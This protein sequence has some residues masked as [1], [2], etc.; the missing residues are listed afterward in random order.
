[1]D[2]IVVAAV[3]FGALL[4]AGWNTLVKSSGDKEL[5]IALV[6]FLGALV[7]LPLLLLVGL[8]PREAWPFLATSLVV[9]LAYYVTLTGAYQHGDLSTTYPIMRGSAPMLVALG[10][11]TVLGESL[12]AAAWI[13]VA[14][15]TAGVLTVGLAR[16]GQAL[17]H[18]RAVAF[19]LANA[20][21][22]AAYTFV[23]GS[24]VRTAVA[25]GSS[26]ASYAVLLFVLDGIPYPGLVWW[27]RS[28]ERRRA[29]ADY[30][31]KRWPLAM[32]GG[33]ASLGS[34][35]IALWAMTQAPVATVSALRET[36]VLFATA[37]SV[38][39]LKEHFGVQR[40][41][42]AVI[43]VAGVVALRLS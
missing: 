3:L 24:G 27:R 29:M 42:G 15:V 43:I 8:P 5:D 26:A 21:V 17:H 25:A 14:A 35:W 7:S 12:S 6:H 18:S 19:A 32:L 30:A 13:G 28:P 22:I 23:D 34:Y 40:A 9:H 39:V 16:P 38:L 10:S 1:V 20:T 31:R 37:L 2:S 11:S 36:S 4:H 33:L 41:V